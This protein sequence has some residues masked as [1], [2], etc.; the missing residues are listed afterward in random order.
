MNSTQ[1]VTATH[2]NGSTIRISRTE[3]EMPRTM[4][5]MRE[6]GYVAF[7]PLPG[8]CPTCD[9]NEPSLHPAVQYGGEVSV[10][11]DTWH[12]LPTNRTR[13]DIDALQ[14]IHGVGP[15]QTS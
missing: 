3:A 8:R 1:T 4:Q 10:C 2:E 6:S 14:A 15:G 5:L 13:Y 11:R 12:L 9:S 7:G